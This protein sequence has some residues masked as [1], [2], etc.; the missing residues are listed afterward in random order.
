MATDEQPTNPRF[1]N[2]LGLNGTKL[3][4]F[5][6]GE[7]IGQGG[8]GVVYE[9]RRGGTTYALKLPLVDSSDEKRRAAAIAELPRVKKE[10]AALQS[11]NHP[12]I[13]Q[14]AEYFTWSPLKDT[15]GDEDGLP[16]LVMR[17]APGV[18][19]DRWVRTATPSL[20]LVLKAYR[21]VLDALDYC[22]AHSFFHRD[23]KPSN[24]LVA[25][26]GRP[27]LIDFGIAKSK[28]LKTSTEVATWIGTTDFFAPEYLQYPFSRDAMRGLAF[29]FTPAQD[30]YALGH[31]IFLT[32]T[33]ATA[34][35]AWKSVLST[36]PS[37]AFMA[38]A[39]R[40]DLPVPSNLN[41]Q[42]PA[43]VD[44]FVAK[45]MAREVSTR[46]HTAREA[47]EVLD[48]LLAANATNVA[49]DVPFVLP[50]AEEC[51]KRVEAYSQAYAESLD[52]EDA[53]GEGVDVSLSALTG[54]GSSQTHVRPQPGS[55]TAGPGAKAPSSSSAAK[56]TVPLRGYTKGQT[57]KSALPH[58]A[59]AKTAAGGATSTPD[60]QNT[61]GKRPSGR[62]QLPQPASGVS[63]SAAPVAH[64]TS[65]KRPSGRSRPAQPA[66]DAA[67]D[68]KPRTAAFQAP[69]AVVAPDFQDDAP[70]T[71]AAPASG[72]GTSLSPELER[73]RDE[74]RDY[75]KP[76]R[77]P[78]MTVLLA[79]G[80]AALLVVLI[81][82]AAMMRPSEPTSTTPQPVSLL[83]AAPDSGAALEPIAAVYQP[84]PSVPSAAPPLAPV[85]LPVA[86]VAANEAKPRPKGT[87]DA[88][89]VDE[90]L[91]REYGGQRPVVA[92]DGTTTTPSGAAPS[93]TS[94]APPAAPTG[95]GTRGVYAQPTAAQSGPGKF[96]VSIGS[97]L[98]GT[99]LKPLDSRIGSMP[100]IVRL[101]RAWAPRGEVLLPT[102]TT[103]YGQA[104]TSSGRFTAT[105][106]RLKLPDGTEAPVQAL[107][108][109][110][111]DKK[112]GLS[113]SRRIQSQGA[114]GP[115]VGEAVARGAAN[116]ALGQVQ[117]GPLAD[118]ARGAGQTVVNQQGGAQGGVAQ[119]ALL[120]DAPVDVTIFVSEAF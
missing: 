24:V 63:A 74:F 95:W 113:P 43:S 59:P 35:S 40:V 17:F 119:D 46:F 88:K 85:P 12:N 14:L 9:A 4:D 72:A 73:L 117:G 51:A 89:A 109:D 75:E 98:S 97:E 58:P 80:A 116:V 103:F 6:L 86:P 115:N 118:V 52:E 65:G 47:L 11:L 67:P 112:P 50:T 42:V 25:S 8:F 13:V 87:A 15:V 77:R 56:Q 60:V 7:V 96:G 92:S 33:G 81:G 27:T 16:I 71:P 101:K 2:L 37:V 31:T 54:D 82:G 84:T 91:R 45:L 18:P 106:A 76:Q 61:S 29:V 66:A 49:F 108:Y 90:I 10:A 68:A 94:A 99:L 34:W 3:R 62:S 100:V 23:L 120:L 30:L 57:P 70:A 19:M 114:G 69:S 107:A 26:D 38:I 39:Q 5:T 22:H 79:G 78:S 28:A 44:S 111:Q 110:A 41:P 93:G 104:S 102:G 105:F 55:Q 48:G 1:V 36:Q 53:D 64:N 83:D 32:L 21:Q 20:R